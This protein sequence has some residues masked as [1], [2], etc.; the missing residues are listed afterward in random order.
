[1]NVDIHYS[2]PYKKQDLTTP[3]IYSLWLQDTRH[4]S[5]RVQNGLVIIESM[6]VEM[7]CDSLKRKRKFEMQNSLS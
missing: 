7:N 2:K 6:I 4:M 5:S 3:K 1:M